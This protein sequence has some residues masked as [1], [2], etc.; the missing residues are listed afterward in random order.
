M[1]QIIVWLLMSLTLSMPLWSGDPMQELLQEV[2]TEHLSRFRYVTDMDNYGVRE[3]WPTVDE[4]MFPDGTI[5]GDCEDYVIVVQD[6]LKRVKGI[7]SKI[8]VVDVLTPEKLSLD[9]DAPFYVRLFEA[10]EKGIKEYVVHAVLIIDDKW[11]IDNLL[12]FVILKEDAEH[13]ID[14]NVPKLDKQWRE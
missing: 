14:W 11:I 1:F 7:D 5:Y 8:K 13:I 12:A 6:Y 3:Y 4:I 10:R 2:H 9:L